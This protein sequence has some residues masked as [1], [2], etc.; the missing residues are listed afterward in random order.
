MG[1][2]KPK[3]A[4]PPQ[5]AGKKASGTS[6]GYVAALAVVVVAVGVAVFWSGGTAPAPQEVAPH[7][8]QQGAADSAQQRTPP[9]EIPPQKQPQTA[10]QQQ[11]K[12]PTKASTPVEQATRVDQMP[13]CARWAEAGEC[14]K[15]PA[16]MGAS[17]QASCPHL[18][19]PAAATTQAKAADSRYTKAVDWA[20]PKLAPELA[21]AQAE[22]DAKGPMTMPRSC[23]DAR[24][25]CA[26]LAR[27]NLSA[28][29]EAP[30]MLTDCAKT[31]GTCHHAKLISQVTDECKDTHEQC[32]NWAAAGECEANRRFML[33]GC[34]VACG[35]CEQKKL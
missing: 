27:W 5:V 7:A 10:K 14:D 34:S 11:Q 16:F 30:F 33:N 25:D 20:T 35:V 21:L 4:K 9:K 23:I 19:Q 28:C 2:N 18:E 12:A 3:A 15:N 22:T 26:K 13:E 1:K 17:C 31:C 6:L 29:G 24:D 8:Q 32:A